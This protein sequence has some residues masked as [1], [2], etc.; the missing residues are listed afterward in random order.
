MVPHIAAPIISGESS[1]LDREAPAAE[2]F[3]LIHLGILN[4]ALGNLSQTSDRELLKGCERD[5]VGAPA[6]EVILTYHQSPD[7]VAIMLTGFVEVALAPDQL[8]K[9]IHCESCRGHQP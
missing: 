3:C 6:E 1:L 5:G 4:G 7:V 8:R 2:A 9:C